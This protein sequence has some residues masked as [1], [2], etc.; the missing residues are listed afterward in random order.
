[1]TGLKDADVT[2]FPE[3]GSEKRLEILPDPQGPYLEGNFITPEFTRNGLGTCVKL[4]NISS[5]IMFSW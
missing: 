5:P 2:F 4:K 1:V 3:T